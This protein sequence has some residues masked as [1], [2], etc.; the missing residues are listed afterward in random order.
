MTEYEQRVLTAAHEASHCAMARLLEVP[1]TGPASIRATEHLFGFAFTGGPIRIAERDH[2]SVAGLPAV[3][4]PARTRRQI[5]C[6]V[7]VLLAGRMGETFVLGPSSGY[8]DD[9]DERQALEL[10]EPLMVK[11]KPSSLPPVEARL[12]ALA[13]TGG[14]RGGDDEM[15]RNLAMLVGHDED[16][17]YAFLEWMRRMTARTM[18]TARRFRDQVEALA[19]E[20]LEH[21]VLG[22]R[23]VRAVLDAAYAGESGQPVAARVK[24]ER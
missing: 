11:P 2:D 7:M 14:P 21:E 5:E 24:E 9:A 19:D 18:Y 8:F 4:W 6:R 17:A 12:L 1:I 3:L 16:E 23:R 20:L 13:E 15:A 22:S 10:A